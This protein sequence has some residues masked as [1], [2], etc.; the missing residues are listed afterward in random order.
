MAN[1][2]TTGRG[3]DLYSLRHVQQNPIARM[4]P[5]SRE[6]AMVYRHGE[7][8]PPAGHLDGYAPSW[9]VVTFVI[10]PQGTAQARVSVQRDFTLLAVNTASSS[11]VSGGF[12]GQMFDV[13]RSVRLADRGLQQALMG[14]NQGPPGPSAAFFL[15]EPYPFHE[16][17]SQILINVQNLE[18]VQNAV[19]IALYGVCLP[20]NRRHSPA[21]EFPGGPVGSA[22]EKRPTTG[23]Q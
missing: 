12:L 4:L 3:V 18:A 7:P 5:L 16:H 2:R 22:P 13:M 15:R 1:Q 20:F 11:N 9:E 23:N 8:S 10:A 21:A 6:Q 19:Q 17:D 14:G